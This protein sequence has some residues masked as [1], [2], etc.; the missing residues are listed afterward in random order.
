IGLLAGYGGVKADGR[1]AFSEAIERFRGNSN[2]GQLQVVDLPGG[3]RR[4]YLNDY[5]AQNIYD[6]Q[7]RKSLA[8][9]TYMLHHLA[10]AYAPGIEKVLCI[11]LGVGIVPSQFAAEGARVDVVE[12]NPA[13]VAV[14]RDYFDCHSEKFQL[15]IGDG[16]QFVNASTNRYD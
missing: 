10:R 8:L 3:N 15:T 4:F 1:G 11:G 14:G 7:E 2:F 16:R 12:I 13:V 5:L 9:F 6:P